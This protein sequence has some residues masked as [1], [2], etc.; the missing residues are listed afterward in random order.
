M[1]TF[2][3]RPEGIKIP[4]DVVR[5]MDLHVGDQLRFVKTP[6]GY[7]LIRIDPELDEQL[8]HA[9]DVIEDNSNLLKR[10]AQ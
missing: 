4:D 9:Y 10:L 1:V 8:K 2:T 6:I 5:D 3:Y 7:E